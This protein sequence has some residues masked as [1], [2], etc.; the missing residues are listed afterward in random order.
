M[1]K[2]DFIRELEA[3]GLTLSLVEDR[4]YDIDQ[5]DSTIRVN[6][7]TGKVISTSIIW[8][9]TQEGHYFWSTKDSLLSQRYH[10]QFNLF[11]TLKKLGI[12]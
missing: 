8:G 11:Y 12:R 5:L 3:V 9:D 7:S 1:T 10:P 4:C 6:D 2:D